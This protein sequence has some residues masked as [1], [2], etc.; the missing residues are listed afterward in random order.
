MKPWLYTIVRNRALNAR[1]DTRVAR[2]RSTDDLDGVRQPDE[3][4]LTNEELARVVAAVSALPEAQREALVRSALEGHTHEQIA[5]ALG[6]SPG[7]G[8]PADLPGAARGSPRRSASL[9]PLPL[10]RAAR[11]LRRRRGGGAAAAVAG[12]SRRS[13]AAPRR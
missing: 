10:V 8:A 7:R 9:I 1:R 2:S 6:S 12:G 11:R 4:V 3:I 5:A 13:L